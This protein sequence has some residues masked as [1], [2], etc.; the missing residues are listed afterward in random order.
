MINHILYRV[1]RYEDGHTNLMAWTPDVSFETREEALDSL[2]AWLWAKYKLD[3]GYGDKPTKVCCE[4]YARNDHLANFCSHCGTRCEMGRPTDY[5]IRSWIEGLSSTTCDS[6]GE[7]NYV[8]TKDKVEWNPWL[9]P[10]EETTIWPSKEEVAIIDQDG[11]VEIAQ[12]ICAIAG[13]DFEDD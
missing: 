10:G 11:E 3:I 7:W 2:A 5:D 12:R 1:S 4:Q 6:F 13:I 9:F 8:E